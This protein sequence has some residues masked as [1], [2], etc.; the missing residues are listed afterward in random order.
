M[1]WAS[2]GESHYLII[3]EKVLSFIWAKC[4]SHMSTINSLSMIEE[5]IV[6]H[7]RPKLIITDLGPSLELNSQEGI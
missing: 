6:V 7:G 2:L 5:I 1:D 4:Y 3:V